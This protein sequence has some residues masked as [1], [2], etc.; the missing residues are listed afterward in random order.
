[1]VG[2][3]IS[4]ELCVNARNRI[5]RN[6]W[7]N[8]EV[9]QSAA[10]SVSLSGLFEGLLMFATPDVY[11]SEEALENI[12]PHLAGNAR[13]VAFGA[14]RAHHG[15]GKILSSLVR[16]AISRLSFST[17]PLPDEAPWRL[18]A[19]HVERLEVEELWGGAMFLA[20]GSLLPK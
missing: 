19:K 11:A 1:V 17:T 9:I 5:A 18:L 3:D 20:S 13:V 12:F 4:P 7:S 6:Q 16:L 14:K 8:V 15:R 2:V 10:Q